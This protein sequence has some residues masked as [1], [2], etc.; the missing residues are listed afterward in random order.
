MISLCHLKENYYSAFGMVLGQI[1]PNECAGPVR[2]ELGY[3]LLWVE[4]SRPGGS[5]DIDKHWSQIETIALNKKKGDWFK[6]WVIS[7]RE[8]FFIHINN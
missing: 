5:P 4:A 2:S 3:H 1:I 7:S 8:K 6:D